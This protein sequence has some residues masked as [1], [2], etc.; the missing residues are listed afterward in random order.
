MSRD[1]QASI[2]PIIPITCERGS[3]GAFVDD[4]T[5]EMKSVFQVFHQEERGDTPYV[6]PATDAEE[7]AEEY[8]E[9]YDQGGDYTVIGGGSIEVRVVEVRTGVEKWFRVEGEAVPHYMARE[10]KD[11][12]DAHPT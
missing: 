8:A 6:V 7:A 10:L 5:G 1:K 9:Q 4:K 3:T 2:S 11:K 12:P